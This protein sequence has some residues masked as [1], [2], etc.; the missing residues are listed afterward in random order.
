[1]ITKLRLFSC[2]LLASAG[3]AG[4]FDADYVVHEDKSLNK[5]YTDDDFTGLY[6]FLKA[7]NC[8]G[9]KLIQCVND[10]T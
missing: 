1:M 10:E 6:Q 7:E 9:P 2:A 4:L 8:N 3:N 5:S